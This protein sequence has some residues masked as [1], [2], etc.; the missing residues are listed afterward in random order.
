MD[1]PAVH[2][3]LGA[4]DDDTGDG[5]IIR[6]PPKAWFPVSDLVPSG[7]SAAGR[8]DHQEL[9]LLVGVLS[10]CK[11]FA[12]RQAVRN[13]WMRLAIPEGTSWRAVFLLTKSCEYGLKHESREHKDLLFLDADESYYALTPK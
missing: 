13:T 2:L 1:C 9:T 6:Y 5:A 8:H 4:D 12:A 7:T 3:D 10:S 11:A